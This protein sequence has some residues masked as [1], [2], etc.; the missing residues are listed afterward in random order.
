M[1]F[2]ANYRYHYVCAL[3]R[4]LLF[5][6]PWTVATRAPLSMDFSRHK[7]GGGC[8]SYF[9]GA[10]WSK[11]WIHSFHGLLPDR[12][13]LYHDATEEVLDT[14]K[15]E[16]SVLDNMIGS[17]LMLLLLLYLLRVNGKISCNYFNPTLDTA[18]SPFIFPHIKSSNTPL[19]K[20]TYL[21][22]S[23]RKQAHILLGSKDNLRV[24]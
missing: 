16:L 2:R 5:A 18:I 7:C 19:W 20:T 17:D 8:H 14:Y 3:N 24:C 4:V 6:T 9:T 21:P 10:S 23:E 1:H 15:L 12:R 13:I 11:D 22:T